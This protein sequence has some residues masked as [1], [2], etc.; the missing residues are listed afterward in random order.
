[1]TQLRNAQTNDRNYTVIDGSEQ[2]PKL[3][4]SS[5]RCLKTSKSVR[6]V[7]RFFFQAEDGIRDYKVTGVQTCALPISILRTRRE[8]LL[9]TGRASRTA[10][11]TWSCSRLTKCV[12]VVM[13]SSS[14]GNFSPSATNTGADRKSVV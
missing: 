12:S 7:F 9:R 2:S 6:D 11:S 8:L 3:N 10:M 1:M 4:G 13:L 14:R 5:E